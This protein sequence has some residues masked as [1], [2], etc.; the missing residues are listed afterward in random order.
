MH[1]GESDGYNQLH[2]K[3]VKGEVPN[4]ADWAE[5]AYDE[6]SVPIDSIELAALPLKDSVAMGRARRVKRQPQW[7]IHES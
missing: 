2:L 5:Q 6:A 3:S 7:F 1:E 4:D